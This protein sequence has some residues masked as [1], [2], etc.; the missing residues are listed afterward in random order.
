SATGTQSFAIP[1][2]LF[3]ADR[4]SVRLLAAAVDGN[5][6]AVS[7]QVRGY[8]Y[9]ATLDGAP[10]IATGKTTYFSVPTPDP[11]LNIELTSLGSALPGGRNALLAQV[12]NTTQAA[13]STT[14][15]LTI[16][17]P[18]GKPATFSQP[19]LIAAGSSTIQLPYDLLN[20]GP[21]DVAFT[22]G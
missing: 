22:L 18:G 13:I 11:R 3:P 19:A 5:A 17:R 7:M 2:A 1:A 6:P 21:H 20:S 10:M 9:H 4:I 8:V 14:P 16:T 15:T 12:T